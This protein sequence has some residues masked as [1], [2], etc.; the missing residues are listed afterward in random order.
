VARKEEWRNAGRVSVGLIK[1]EGNLEDLKEDGKY[2]DFIN[3][4]NARTICSDENCTLNG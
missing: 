4:F 1:Q 2:N 3:N